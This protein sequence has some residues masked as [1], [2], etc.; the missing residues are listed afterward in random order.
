MHRP[1]LR[2]RALAGLALLLLFAFA[3][4]CGDGGGQEA[5]PAASP[6]VAAEASTGTPT[7]TATAAAF[8]V[9]VQRSDG[10]SLTLESAPQ[11]I[12][13]LDPS[14]TEILYAIGAGGQVAAADLFSNYPAE[15]A[16]KA[17]LDAFNPSPEAILAEEPD[18]VVLFFD[19][20]GIVAQLEGLGVPVLLLETPADLDGVYDRIR[21][22]GLVTGHAPEAE[23]LVGEMQGRVNAVLERLAPVEEGP[24]VFHE[25]DPQLFS[26][27]PGSFI[28]NLYRLL[29]ARNI[30]AETGQ[31]YPQL[32]A[33]AIIA[34]DPEVIVLADEAS[35][36]TSESVAARPGWQ[37]LSAVKLGR[38]HVVDPDVVSRPGPR[39]VQ[40]LEL[41][42][43][44]LYPEL[45]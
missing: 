24:R 38:V 19:A 14:G 28:D 1:E 35:G 37:T 3:A 9:T 29:K 26:V 13:S 8:P 34:A 25:L 5:P 22:L 41:L 20:G 36:V 32:T 39:V 7:E 30:A 10:K 18:L 23:Q 27:G 11:R 2:R 43:Q 4:A 45:Y 44:L 31:P 21:T 15:A 16:G 42:A 17:K 40:A 33:E 6:T 12:V